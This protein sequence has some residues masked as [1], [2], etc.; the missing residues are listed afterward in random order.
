MAGVGGRSEPAVPLE[1]RAAP[2]GAPIALA[3]GMG[4]KGRNEEEDIGAADVATRRGGTK[5][6]DAHPRY[7]TRGSATPAAR[8]AGVRMSGTGPTPRQRS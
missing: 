2:A 1:R 6:S 8:S 5:G 4:P 3:M 7:P